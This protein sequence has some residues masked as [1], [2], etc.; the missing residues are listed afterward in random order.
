[1]SDLDLYSPK[2]NLR[3]EH[4]LEVLGCE[5]PAG[6]ALVSRRGLVSNPAARSPEVLHRVRGKTLACTGIVPLRRAKLVALD[7]SM[8]ARP[9]FKGLM[10][11][12]YL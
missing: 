9:L 11:V 1:V 4:S 5:Q 12:C 6:V 3:R 7:R 10:L 2:I 8:V